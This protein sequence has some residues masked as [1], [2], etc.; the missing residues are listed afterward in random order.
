MDLIKIKNKEEMKERKKTVYY[1][2]TIAEKKDKK[3]TQVSKNTQQL[4]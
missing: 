2:G 3:T 4:I 1:N